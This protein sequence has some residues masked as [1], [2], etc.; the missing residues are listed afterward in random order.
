M[1]KNRF[2]ADERDAPGWSGQ[3]GRS[4]GSSLNPHPSPIL[5]GDQVDTGLCYSSGSRLNAK[6]LIFGLRLALFLKAD[7]MS[8]L[9]KRPLRPTCCLTPKTGLWLYEQI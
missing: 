8:V 6:N 5:I 7:G 9:P 2:I 4:E 3:A 1:E